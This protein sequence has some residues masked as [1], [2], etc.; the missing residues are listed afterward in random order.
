MAAGRIKDGCTVLW[1]FTRN[2]VV[3]GETI[4]YVTGGGRTRLLGIIYLYTSSL[5]R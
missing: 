4:F 3:E 1:A 2:G 5:F